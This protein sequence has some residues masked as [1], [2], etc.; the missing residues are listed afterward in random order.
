MGENTAVV[1]V[2]L[3]SL[4]ILGAILFLINVLDINALTFFSGVS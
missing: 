4:I 1:Y 3:T 2:F